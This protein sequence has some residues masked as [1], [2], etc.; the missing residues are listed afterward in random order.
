MKIKTVGK[1]DSHIRAYKLRARKVLS[2][3]SEEFDQYFLVGICFTEGRSEL[4]LQPTN[5]KVTCI[6]Q[7]TKDMLGMSQEAF[8]EIF[9]LNYIYGERRL[10]LKP[11]AKPAS[12]KYCCCCCCKCK[13]QNL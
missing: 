8:N 5:H 3:T 2:M 11:E 10:C 13:G 12:D 6:N 1:Y 7:H 9:E 4:F